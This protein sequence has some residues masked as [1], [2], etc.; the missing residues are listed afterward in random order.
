MNSNDPL[1]PGDSAADDSA[2]DGTVAAASSSSV[3]ES[4]AQGE[5]EVKQEEGGTKPQV[6]TGPSL[7]AVPKEQS[8][9]A[10][11]DKSTAY[12]P[13]YAYPQPTPITTVTATTTITTTTGTG[14]AGATGWNGGAH[15]ALATTCSSQ[16]YTP[17]GSGVVSWGGAQQQPQPDWSNYH[18]GNWQ[19][20]G[21][22][23]QQQQQPPHQQQQ[24]QGSDQGAQWGSGGWNQHQ[25]VGQGGVATGQWAGQWQGQPG[26]EAWSGQAYGSGQTYGVYQQQ[27]YSYPSTYNNNYQGPPPF[28]FGWR[29]GI[30]APYMR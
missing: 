1:P 13:G 18:Q 20:S 15:P 12:N 5:S 7:D 17:Q 14:A 29:G 26:V 16:W 9:V 22:S 21:W 27:D 30:V 8:G 2:A 6:T 19:Q 25:W 3:I 11:S 10:D 23:P 28:L 4:V 24:Q